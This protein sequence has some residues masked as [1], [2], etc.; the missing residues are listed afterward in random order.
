VASLAASWGVA[1]RPSLCQPISIHLHRSWGRAG[2]AQEQPDDDRCGNLV[3]GHR[4][5]NWSDYL[6]QRSHCG[7]KSGCCQTNS[8]RCACTSCSSADRCDRCRQ[9]LQTDLCGLMHA[10][11]RAGRRKLVPSLGC[12]IMPS[13]D[14]TLF[15]MAGYP[16]NGDPSSWLHLAEAR[17]F[18]YCPA[19]VRIPQIALPRRA[20]RV[21]EVRDAAPSKD[22]FGEP[23]W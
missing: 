17:L 18:M 6:L 23:V 5:E 22:E 21:S 10:V 16:R 9:I 12:G 8:V 20:F 19:R 7:T 13:L 3:S 14:I 11:G 4:R 2:P 15:I 1:S